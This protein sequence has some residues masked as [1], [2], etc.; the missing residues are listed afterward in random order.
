MI[1]SGPEL[2]ICGHVDLLRRLPLHHAMHRELIETFRRKPGNYEGRYNEESE[3]SASV[4]NYGRGYVALHLTDDITRPEFSE[5]LLKK[6]WKML[7]AQCT[8]MDKGK[9]VIYEKW[10][11]KI[12][13][14]PPK[15]V[16]SAYRSY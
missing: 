10:T 7:N 9:P 1:G 8:V 16:T 3:S 12:E 11:N 6:G 5:F 15:R 4:I 2:T 13:D 14:E